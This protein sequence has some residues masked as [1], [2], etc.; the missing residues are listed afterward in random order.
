M[1]LE[2]RFDWKVLLASVPV[3]LAGT[4]VLDSMR[5]I[6]QAAD[7]MPEMPQKMGRRVL[8]LMSGETEVGA[9]VNEEPERKLETV[10]G[11][12]VHY[13]NGVILAAL[14]ALVVPRRWLGAP[15][16]VA[17]ALGFP[18][19]TMMVAMLPAMGMGIAGSKGKGMPRILTSTGI[20]HIV[21]GAA[22]G[23]MTRKAAQLTER[24]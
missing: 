20:A 15:S 4:W 23:S 24:L 2:R 7:M 13:L 11:Y 5:L 17:Y 8:N 18:E 6:F 9:N 12:Q 3:G 1:L 22:L 19:A 16:G 21:W 14:Y 10:A